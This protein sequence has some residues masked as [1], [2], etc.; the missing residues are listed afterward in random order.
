MEP[1]NRRTR[2]QRLLRPRSA[3]FVGGA[4]LEAAIAE[5]Q[6]LGFSGQLYTVNPKRPS[7][8][9]IPCHRSVAA[10][11]KVPDLAFVAVPKEAI[12]ATISALAQRGVGA[13]ICNTAGFSEMAGEGLERQAALIA[14]ASEMPLLGPNCPGMANFADGAVFMMDHFG[15][16]SPGPGIA[17][18]SNGGA[19]LSDLGCQ[20]R[21]LAVAYLIGLGNQAVVSMAEVF[22]LLV[23]DPRVTAINLYFETLG[24][25]AALSRAAL[26][27]QARDLPVVAI[28]GG[29]S[30]SG[31]R[32]A[33]SHTASLAGEAA[34]ASALFERLGF[35]EVE[36]QS[37]AIETLKMLTATRRPRGRRLG[38]ATSS[39]SYAVLGADRAEAL[40]LVLPP[41][42][43]STERL[44]TL[45][46]P[47]VHPANPLD[48]ATDHDASEEDQRAIYDAFL[49]DDYDMAVQVMC[50]PPAEGWDQ[51]GWDRATR[52]FAKAAAARGLPAAFI[53][54]LGEALPEQARDRMLSLGMAPLM[55]LEEGARALANASLYTELRSSLEERE[56]DDIVLPEPLPVPEGT[57][58]S[59]VEAKARL[60][61]V[62]LSVPN[63]RIWQDGPAPLDGLRPPF[64]LK[65]RA[66]NLLHKSELGA[67]TL[68]LPDK[69]SVDAAAAEMRCRLEGR[70]ALEGFLVEE[71]VT[72]ARAE[73]LIGIRRLPAVGLALTLASGGVAA[74]LL[75]DRRTI[76]LPSSRADIEAA[77]RRLQLFP[78]LDGWRA[79]PR[80]DLQ[81]VLDTVESLAALVSTDPEIIELEVNPLLVAAE[82]QGV[83][84]V[85]AVMTV[86]S[87]SETKEK[88]RE[89]SL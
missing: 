67:V 55:G 42:A 36:T 72:A 61:A 17:V 15:R 24:D 66:P 53:N 88:T 87:A 20:T 51:G 74:E 1:F 56:T 30:Q 6:A 47:F 84:L 75:R 19:Y 64:V 7:L 31:G 86:A 2:L 12:L 48:I 85:D 70:I 27:A 79:A 78:L 26:K 62:G 45:L 29:R 73:L 33:Q 3:V 41:P 37:E 35:V 54:T 28:K 16:H 57:L 52:A 60:T 83:A 25:V 65:A 80:C 9:G 58:L 22:D 50:Y 10:L 23:E 49:A 76:L 38:L 69:A 81:A 43:R 34:I 11:P 77:L 21:G 4:T 5:C 13:A 63:H 59:E 40:G 46:P 32:A 82:G 18:I 71:M 8:A 39:G 89:R 44:A 68:S 14:A